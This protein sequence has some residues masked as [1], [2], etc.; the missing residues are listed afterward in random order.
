MEQERTTDNTA[1]LTQPARRDV[2]RTY[3]LIGLSALLF[4]AANGGGALLMTLL[5]AALAQS[6]LAEILGYALIYA[7]GLLLFYLP[8]G[9]RS[10]EKAPKRALSAA[11]WF[12]C[13]SVGYLFLTVGNLIG[14]GVDAAL[15]VTS[16]TDS[17]LSSSD[18]WTVLLPTVV[19]APICEELMFRKWLLDRT[20][21]F[22][23]REAAVFSALLFALMHGN[24]SQAFY[25]FGLGLVFAAVYLKTRRIQYTILMHAFVN[26]VSGVLPAALMQAA[27]RR[28]ASG[29]PE[30]LMLGAVT[31]GL[32]AAGLVL[33]IV[34]AKRSV[35]AKSG[36][37]HI[38]RL[39]YGNAGVIMFL[40]VAAAMFAATSGLIPL[41]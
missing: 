1:P 36:L 8:L 22:G 40:I 7:L 37:P 34:Y 20:A 16:V 6:R 11:E 35:P 39:Q 12:G 26:F 41:D 14:V 17:Y 10:A 29:M 2:R 23:P 32:A 24:F 28:G 31:L 33:L 15:G 19:F 25:A 18:L 4:L 38:A 9:R 21:A 13:L 3:S 30:T 27:E 5:P